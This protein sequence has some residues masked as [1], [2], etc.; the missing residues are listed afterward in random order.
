MKIEDYYFTAMGLNKSS[1]D[2]AGLF[3]FSRGMYEIEIA[4]RLTDGDRID[5]GA[6]PW[7]S[8]ILMIKHNRDPDLR[9]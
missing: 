4:H 7:K 6:F 8:S 1:L 5:L 9:R 2:L 3:G